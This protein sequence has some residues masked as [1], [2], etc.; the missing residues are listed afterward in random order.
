V[1]E[2]IHDRF[3]RVV[4]VLDP[5]LLAGVLVPELLNG[6]VVQPIL[7]SVS[8]H[9]FPED[10]TLDGSRAHSFGTLFGELRRVQALVVVLASLLHSIAAHVV[11]SLALS[12][13]DWTVVLKS[14]FTE[15]V[16]LFAGPLVLRLAD[17]FSCLAGHS[18]VFLADLVCLSTVVS[19]LIHAVLLVGSTVLAVLPLTVCLAAHAVVFLTLVVSG[20]ARLIVSALAE[21]TA[22]RAIERILTDIL[23]R[24]AGHIPVLQ[25]RVF[26]QS[27]GTLIGIAARSCSRLT[28]VATA[29]CVN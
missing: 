15:G 26:C 16:V 14:R 29:S 27:T 7:V 10:G 9:S 19:P 11:T 22:S 21:V 17:L 18:I 4:L 23:R 25:A 28:D 5:T 12:F 24:S 8:S 2:L 6:R 20:S 1:C 3:D 13:S